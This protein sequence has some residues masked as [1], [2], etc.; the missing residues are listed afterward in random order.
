MNQF[1]DI[2]FLKNEQKYCQFMISLVSFSFWLYFI[3]FFFAVFL[4]YFVPGDILINKLKL[5]FFQRIVI[6]MVIGMVLWGWQGFIFGYL[7]IRWA[8]Y[9]LST[10]VLIFWIRNNFL[11]FISNL[12][13]ELKNVKIDKILL[14]LIIFGVTSQLLSVWFNGTLF[15]DRLYFCCSNAF[16]A[17]F[18]IALT[19]SLTKNF[20]PYE[21][22][23]YGV[24]VQNY[25]YWGNLVLAELIRVFRLPL[26]PLQYQY[27]TLFIS[28]LLGLAAIVF[29]QISNLG[30]IY[31]RWLLFFLYF[32]GDL[33]FALVSFMRRELNFQMSSLE[34]GAK[35]LVNPPRA[36]SVV[37]F[38]VGLSLLLL[39]LRKKDNYVGI[40]MAL[41]MGSLIGF[42]VYT[43]IFVCSGFFFLSI[44]FLIKRSYRS[45]SILSL[46]LIVSLIV[47]LP[48]N[49]KAGGLYFTGF[50]LFE[51]FIVQPWMVLDRLEL[52]RIIYL[53]HKS[54]FRVIQYESLYIVLYSLTVF[55]SKL[56][57]LFQTK[58]SLSLFPIGFHVFMIGG[59][60]VSLVLGFFFQQST[61][62][63]NTFNFLVSVFIIGS[64][65]SSLSATYIV[66]KI[67]GKTALVFVTLMVIITI[68]RVL[69]DGVISIQNLLSGKGFVISHF[70]IDAFEYLRR[71]QEDKSMILVDNRKFYS[72]AESTYISFL[73]DRP[74][75]ISGI[76][77]LRSHGADL[78]KR[79]RIRDTFF[80]TTDT[81][82]MGMLLLNNNIGHIMMYSPQKLKAEGSE[83]FFQAEY[84]NS[85]I[86]ILKVSKEAIRNYL[87]V[88]NK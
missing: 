20:P 68:P 57:A 16:D 62:G 43:G 30:K 48:V 21:P 18:Q 87:A 65:Y 34:D 44:H 58:K 24:L 31:A 52:A 11:I 7:G 19:N 41:V 4:A 63:A 73:A 40:L 83:R 42:K 66:S 49:D 84:Q 6:A 13:L 71:T 37:I 32:G 46:V 33:I 27:S 15:I 61:G 54:W 55:G 39:W 14:I 56:I 75:F 60:L 67:S 86:K 47:Y 35:F 12:K 23:M 80:S 29:S 22:G 74:L 17:F 45:I 70:E 53:K 9:F 69:H 8:S 28:F 5:S 38:F 85:Q 25:H 64:V 10:Y 79:K 50:S 72:D 3:Y 88:E 51:N 77:V 78:S 76:G 36:I 82:L 59:L 26:I 81:S 1:L 2:L